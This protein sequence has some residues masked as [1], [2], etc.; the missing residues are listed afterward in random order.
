MAS[1]SSEPV[2]PR[3]CPT[4]DMSVRR[5][6]LCLSLAAS[7][8]TASAAVSG[9]V[10]ASDGHPLAGIAVASYALET[11]ETRAER[12][13]AGQDRRALATTRSAADGSFRVE[14]DDAVVLLGVRADG[15]APVAVVAG[16]AEPA[17]LR[18]KPAPMRRGTLM[19]SGRPVAEATLAW[20]ASWQ[21]PQ[22]AEMIVHSA[23]DGAYEVPDPDQWASGVAVVHRD[24][25]LA[26]VTAEPKWGSRLSQE[27]VAGVSLA[28]QVV[29]ERSGRGLAGA[30]V[31]V[32]G[33]PRARSAVDGSF[34]I[35]HAGTEEK[36]VVARTDAL[37]GLARAGG[38]RLLIL[39]QDVRRI[40]GL[41]RDA[42]TKQPIAGAV[43]VALDNVHG[44]YLTAISDARGQY[45]LA[46]P[47]GRY[48]AL[49]SGPGYASGGAVDGAAEPIDLRK[50][51]AAGRDFELVPLRR[52]T[53]RV[54]DERGMP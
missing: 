21:D 14:G 28:G 16:P 26:L 31:W 35:P 54:Q 49:A 20:L 51:L 9:R 10:V 50:S 1:V 8:A 13:M 41:V 6:L 17:T 48:Q 40:S 38:E 11:I 5:A 36:D 27:L 3:R 18:L 42:K 33:W 43:V 12:I 7:A 52:A 39:A 24:F 15:F 34:T 45:R 23:K 47:P 46:L 32:A 25:A 44:R 29:D 4:S 22:S 19:A 30:T 2:R 37:A 53:G